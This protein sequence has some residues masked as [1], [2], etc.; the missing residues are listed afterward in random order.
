MEY[1]KLGR[2]GLRVSEVAFGAWAIGGPSALGD[3]QIG[4]GKVDDATSVRALEAAVDA[5]VNFF[6]TADVYGAG[7]SEEL[8]G[9][10]FAG[11][12][13]RI[14]ISSKVGNRVGPDNKWFK[15][16]SPAWINE[17]IEGS[18]KRLQT[19][20][21]D[22]YH[23]HSP[24][25][26]FVYTDE[27]VNALDALKKQGKI[28]FYGVSLTP[29]GRGIRPS[30]QG[31]RIL[32]T[33]KCDF[34][35]VVYNML[36]REP[37]D[38]LLPACQRENVGI[39]ARVPLA[40]GFLTGKF[41]PDARFP[42]DDHRRAKYPPDKVRETVDKVERL[43]F[44]VEGKD[45]T[46]AQAALQYCLSHPA[47]S[48]VIPGAKTPDQARDNAAASDRVLLAREELSKV[49]ELVPSE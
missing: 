33:G 7:H 31:L 1:R 19:D 14:I 47:V 18:L 36:E 42:E 3:T 39:I 24:G 21:V 44:L 49:R 28:R 48:T 25:A 41:G 10:T 32:K 6:D 4:W 5:G 34:F 22:L 2:T 20:Y 46:L 23:L 15:D 16:F 45:K 11:R 29:A 35:Q 9:R 37:E 8:I 30:D 17:A 26:D 38:E 43:R 40:S 12:R 27:I 13:D